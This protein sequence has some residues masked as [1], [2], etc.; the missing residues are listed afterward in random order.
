[1]WRKAHKRTFF[2]GDIL[3]YIFGKG[4]KHESKTEAENSKQD[5]IASRIGG[6]SHT[7]SDSSVLSGPGFCGFKADQGRI[8]YDS[9]GKQQQLCFRHTQLQYVE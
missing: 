5:Q 9:I 2:I 6:R 7:L 4:E 3:K 8:L 1:M